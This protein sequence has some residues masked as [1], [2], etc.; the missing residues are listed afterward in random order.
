MRDFLVVL[1]FAYLLDQFEI[2]A[3]VALF[4]AWY[5]EFSGIGTYLAEVLS[6]V[7]VAF[8]M[9]IFQSRGISSLVFGRTA[10]TESIISRGIVAIAS[11][12]VVTLGYHDY[13]NQTGSSLGTEKFYVGRVR[14]MWL[15]VLVVAL[16]YCVEEI[17][18]S[19]HMIC[20]GNVACA[21]IPKRAGAFESRWY[22]YLEAVSFFVILVDLFARQSLALSGILVGL[23]AGGV[24]LAAASNLIAAAGLDDYQSPQGTAAGSPTGRKHV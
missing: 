12:F 13:I 20:N 5:S 3:V 10:T 21:P 7:A 15:L 24:L 23:V 14:S 8:V 17:A 19:V 9:R 6:A 4:N 18:S 11:G 22:L 2:W 1:P 16:V